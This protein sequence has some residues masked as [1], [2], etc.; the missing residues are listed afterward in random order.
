MLWVGFHLGK[1][2]VDS[3]SCAHCAEPLIPQSVCK[4]K[5]YYIQYK[6]SNK[7]LNLLSL[8]QE[9]FAGF[10]HTRRDADEA[11]SLYSSMG[12]EHEP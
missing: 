7:P 3:H 10:F 1:S 2:I 5:C 8:S 6:Q 12:F 11:K 9:N 4:N